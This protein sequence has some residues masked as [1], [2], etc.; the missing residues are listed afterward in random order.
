[1]ITNTA[2]AD[3]RKLGMT[4]DE[5]AAFVQATTRLGLPGDARITVSIGWSGQIESITAAGEAR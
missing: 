2:E 3:D 1:M 5:L 4:L